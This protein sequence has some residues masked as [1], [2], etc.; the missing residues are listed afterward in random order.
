MSKVIRLKESDIYRMVNE[1]LNEQI[2][3]TC[4]P[5]APGTRFTAVIDPTCGK[6]VECKG[7][8]CSDLH[9]GSPQSCCDDAKVGTYKLFNHGGHAACNCYQSVHK[10]FCKGKTNNPNPSGDTGGVPDESDTPWIK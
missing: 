8:K 5:C 1:V 2:T 10:S 9:K 4:K 3:T 7:V 6:R